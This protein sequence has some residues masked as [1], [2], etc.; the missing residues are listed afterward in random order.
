[1]NALRRIPDHTPKKAPIEDAFARAELLVILAVL[2]LLALV[3]LPAL[4]NNR[5][6][7]ARVICANNLRQIGSAMQLW[8]NDHEDLAPFDV[9]VAEGGTRG[10]P[11]APNVWF[12]FAIMSNEL[13]SPRLLFCPT[14]SGNPAQDFTGNPTSGYLHPNF[15]N[16]ATSYLLAHGLSGVDNG[17]V[18]ADR[19]MGSEQISGCPIFLTGVRVAFFP[20]SPNLSWNTNLH[21]NSGNLLRG[22]GSAEQHSNESMRAAIAAHPPSDQGTFHYV[23]PR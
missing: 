16:R 4:A 15:A 9:P 11:L 1:M 14:D 19:N 3:V 12:H 10:H 20:L 2:A 8:G 22:D 21:S 17:M 7:S 6:R 23:L 5:P 13:V 18:A